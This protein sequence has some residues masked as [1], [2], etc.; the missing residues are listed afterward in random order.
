MIRDPALAE[1]ERDVSPSCF[2]LVFHPEIGV[3]VA[4]GKVSKISS[5]SD[6]CE[7]VS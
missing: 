5:V 7:V 6:F 2:S 3:I 4:I 1:A